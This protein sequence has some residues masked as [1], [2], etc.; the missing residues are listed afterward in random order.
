MKKSSFFIAIYCY[1]TLLGTLKNNLPI[2]FYCVLIR[3]EI[4]Q[5]S[6]HSYKN[7]VLANIP[8]VKGPVLVNL[9]YKMLCNIVR[10]H[11]K[12]PKNIVCQKCHG[13][14]ICSEVMQMRVSS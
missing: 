2:F 5:M 9:Q 11:F 4:M 3:S 14:L 13:L 8:L 12:E 10:K 1:K 7:V 6:T